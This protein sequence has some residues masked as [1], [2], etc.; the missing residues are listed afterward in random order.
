MPAPRAVGGVAVFL[1][2]PHAGAV[3]TRITD[4]FGIR[5][6]I[7]QAGMIYCSGG[8]LA[9]AVSDAGGLGLIGAG[10][11]TA[12]QLRDEIQ[13]ARQ[14]TDR[15]LGVNV[16]VFYGH[17][18]AAVE[19]ALAAGVRIFFMSGG[20]PAVFTATLKENGCTVVHVVGTPRQAEKCQEAGC[21]AVVCEG[22]EAGGHNSPEEITTLVLV[23]QVVDAVTI[24]VIAAGGIGDGRAIAAVMALGADGAQLGTRFA[25]T[26]ESAASPAFKQTIVQA[27]P[28][29]TRLLM[30]KLMPVRLYLNDF[31]KQVMQAEAEGASRE[32][33]SE[34]LGRGRARLGILEGDVQQGE[35]EIGQI[36]GAIHDIPTAREVIERLLKEYRQ[37]SDRLPI[38]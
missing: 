7:V 12:D 11:M 18:S 36:A 35:V 2:L 31:A 13:Q 14:L 28:G 37:A 3:R 6:P 23:P 21:D 16:P 20:S 34:L 1:R 32:D 29:D 9:A 22:F 27:G 15:P 33:L 19:V 5:Y 24:P 25:C 30:K 4:L 17:A 8:H 38:L 26:V 10:S